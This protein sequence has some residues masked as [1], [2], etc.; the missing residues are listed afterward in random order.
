LLCTGDIA[1]SRAYLDRAIAVYDPVVHAP[2]ATRFGQDVG[3]AALC[4]RSR[5]L[6][7]LG[8]PDAAL[9]DVGQAVANA[10]ES[11]QATTLMYTLCHAPFTH[12]CCGNHAIAIAIIDELIRL[13]DEK[14]AA[15]WKAIG[16]LV[17]GWCLATTAKASDAVHT[18]ESGIAALRSTGGSVWMPLHFTYLA[19]A[20]AELGQFDDA[21]RCIDQAVS[22]AEATKEIWWDAEIHRVAGEIALQSPEPQAA[23][24]EVC[25]DRALAVARKQRTKS[26]ELRVTVSMARLWRQ[27]GKREQACNHLASVYG[28]FTEGFDTLDLKQAKLLLDELA[29]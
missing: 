7:M 21:W 23:K 14:G 8:Y 17:R 12:I 20:Y 16:M 22:A 13:A 27:Q 3:V 2:L 19:L 26:F 15:I 6:W 11:G 1:E 4:Y 10:R 18:I 5:A 25:F 24:A 9:K 29:P 28:W